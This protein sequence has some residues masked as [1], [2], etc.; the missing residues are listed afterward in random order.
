[1]NSLPQVSSPPLYIPQRCEFAHAN[2]NGEFGEYDPEAKR[3]FFQT[4]Y[5]A[6]AFA[7]TFPALLEDGWEIGYMSPGRSV[8]LTVSW[9]NQNRVANGQV[10]VKD[11]DGKARTYKRLTPAS[12]NRLRQ[13]WQKSPMSRRDMTPLGQRGAVYAFRW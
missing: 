9:D 1:M 13:L 4:P 11:T 2:L 6:Q 10:S 3:A 5:R 12:F 8:T 7:Q